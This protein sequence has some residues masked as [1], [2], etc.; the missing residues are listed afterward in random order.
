MKTGL[1]LG[2]E[3]GFVKAE[4][5]AV[6]GVMLGPMGGGNASRAPNLRGEKVVSHQSMA[7]RLER[8]QWEE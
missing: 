3:A 2:L 7:A 6:E 8:P 5:G 1:A 4:K